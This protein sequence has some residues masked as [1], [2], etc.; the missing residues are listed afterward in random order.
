MATKVSSEGGGVLRADNH[1]G[2]IHFEEL[3][4]VPAQLRH[5]L[6]AEWSGEAAIENQQHVLAPGKIGEGH[7]SAVEIREN[8][9]RRPLIKGDLGHF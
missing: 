3:I 1:N 9:V 8:K 5:V 7:V 2:C 4:M 6:A